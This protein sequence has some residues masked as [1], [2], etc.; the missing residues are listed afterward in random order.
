VIREYAAEHAP[1]GLSGAGMPAT[2]ESIR[3]WMQMRNAFVHKG[4]RIERED[5]AYALHLNEIV[6]ECLRHEVGLRK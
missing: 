5:K 2:A 1:H 3:K 6:T 4:A